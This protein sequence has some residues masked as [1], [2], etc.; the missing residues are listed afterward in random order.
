MIDHVEVI[1]GSGTVIRYG[2]IVAWAAPSA[3]SA[4]ISFLA[5]SARNLGPSA[6]GGQQIAEHIS[7]VLIDRDPEP[8]VPFV[9]IGPSPDGWTALLH[10]PVQVWEG[11]RWLAPS[12]DPGWMRSTVDPQPAITVGAAGSAMP[13]LSP[14]SMWD[15]EA[16]VVPG[17][18]FVLVPASDVKPAKGG[19]R[20]R[21]CGAGR[22]RFG[23]RGWGG[24][25]GQERRRR[26][27]TWRSCRGWCPRPSGSRHRWRAGTG[28][29]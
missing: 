9:V 26:G 1:A 13:A 19:R 23:D 4:L 20:R 5:Q 28:S 21:E 24:E 25:R 7:G 22:D 6:R 8:R 10:G 17:S 2:S 16:G 14:D 27:R 3:S 11:A 15:L 12:P 18:G 29:G